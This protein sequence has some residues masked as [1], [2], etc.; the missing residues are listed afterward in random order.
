MFDFNTTTK[1]RRGQQHLFLGNMEVSGVQS[2][3]MAFSNPE[4]PIVHLGIENIAYRSEGGKGGQARAQAFILGHDHFIDLTGEA[5][6]NGYL[7]KTTK[8]VDDNFSFESGYLTQ[9]S[10]RCSVGELP[11]VGAQFQVFGRIGKLN[12]TNSDQI[13][14]ELGD[15]NNETGPTYD[16]ADVNAGSIDINFGEEFEQDRITS[17]QFDIS[18]PRKPYYRLGSDMP[19]QVNTVYPMVV[20]LSMSIDLSHFQPRNNFDN[21]CSPDS[22]NFNLRLK[23]FHNDNVVVEYNFDNMRLYSQSYSVNAAGAPVLDLQY[24]G[25]VLKPGV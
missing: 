19:I 6:I 11:Q 15:I 22:G 4:E 1:I 14:A 23:N 20:Q 21:P 16:L 25:M 9:Y 10:Q 8:N 17:Y 3:D 7:I 18:V 2:F 13:D 24:N 5:G 12:M